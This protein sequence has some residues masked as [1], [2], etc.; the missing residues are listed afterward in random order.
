MAD[1]SSIP[2]AELIRRVLASFKPVKSHGGIPLWSKAMGVFGLGST[3]AWQLCVRH[4][5][6][7]DLMVRK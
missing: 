7:P 5:F 6:D 1:V 2:D 3:Y 4:G